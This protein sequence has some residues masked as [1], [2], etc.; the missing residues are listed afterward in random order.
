MKNRQSG[1][2]Q[3]TASAKS[4]ISIRSGRR[5]EKGEHESQ[6]PARV[7]RTRKDPI[8][9]IWQSDLLPLLEGEPTLTGLTL[10]EYLEETYP[11]QYPYSLLRTIQRRVKHYKAT[12]GPEKVVIF[13]QSV[14]PGHQGFSDF[15]H[16]NSPITLLG[17]PFKHILYQY[18]LAFSGWRYVQTIQGGESYSALADGLQTALHKSG[19]SPTEHR[20]DH[21]SAAYVN[22]AQKKYLTQSY[23]GLCQHYQ[24]KAT[25]LK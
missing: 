4:G 19:G 25:L 2:T 11:E 6:S 3:E 22:N 24:M 18:R 7:Y 10:W 9:S 14:P 16:P 8:E 17:K 23:D 12:Q 5:I 1:H 13:R 15:T 20:T 21:L